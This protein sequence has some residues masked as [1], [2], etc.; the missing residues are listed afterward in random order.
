[1]NKELLKT[2]VSQHIEQMD[3]AEIV[4]IWNEYCSAGGDMD[5]YIYHMDV[6]DE[7]MSGMKPWEIA[8]ACYY[9]GNFCPAHNYFWFNGYGNLESADTIW[10]GNNDES[11]VYIPEISAYIVDEED[12][13]YND[14]IQEILDDFDKEDY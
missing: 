6:F 11:P 4:A 14:E 9:G 2:V 12:A 13:L 7:I 3:S 10:G 8:R 1:M 5:N